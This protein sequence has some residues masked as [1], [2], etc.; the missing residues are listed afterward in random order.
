[1]EELNLA[2][3]IA[4]W[5]LPVLFAI[6]LHEVAHGWVASL[7]GDNTAKRL[8]RLSLNPLHHIDPVGTLLIPGITLLL[9]GIIFGW[10]KPVPVDFT[11]LRNPRRDMVLVALAGPLSN[12]LMAV[13]WA[14]VARLAVMAHTDFIT[15]PLGY[16]G[17][18]GIVINIIL[19]VLNLF[20]LPP[21]DGGRVA[22]GLLPPR[23]GEQFSRIEPYG[24]PILLTL[25]LT[26]VL[27][28]ILGGPMSVL[29][30]LLFAI[31]GL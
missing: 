8:G 16:M 18:A 11:R 10:A 3:K 14:L 30:R 5:A 23:L 24:F 9:G 19:M 2:Q 12:L 26:G 4:V 22:V 29:Q 20:P 21:L 7:C 31:A 6:T 13:G 17:M 1:M 28:H 27:G 15:Q 25:L